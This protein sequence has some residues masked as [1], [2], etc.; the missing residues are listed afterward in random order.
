VIKKQVLFGFLW[1]VANILPLP[2]YSYDISDMTLGPNSGLPQYGYVDWVY[3][4]GKIRVRD[5][6]LAG[7]DKYDWG[8]GICTTNHSCVWVRT[9]RGGKVTDYK[10]EKPVCLPEVGPG[11]LSDAATRMA[12][13]HLT[14]IIP[15]T[16]DATGTQPETIVAIAVCGQNGNALDYRASGA[17]GTSLICALE[18]PGEVDFPALSYTDERIING[19]FRCSG[20]GSAL[21]RVT[22]LGS[23]VEEIAPGVTI[24]TRTENSAVTVNGDSVPVPVR[25]SVG[26]NNNTG[27]PG[28]YNGYFIYAVDYD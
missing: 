2:V 5:I 6:T 21:A 14:G 10:V 9:A 26:A 22:V 27:E 28:V 8:G 23:D 16:G 18:L 20:G 15:I 13:E 3:E 1:L 24:W 12:R 4:K 17:P 25:L 11:P 19:S 7:G